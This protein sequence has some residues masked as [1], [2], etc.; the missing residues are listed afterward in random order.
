MRKVLRSIYLDQKMDEA[1]AVRADVE[2]T[3]KAELMRDFIAAGLRRPARN[4]AGRDEAQEVPDRKTRGSARAVVPTQAQAYPPSPPPPARAGH[5]PPPAARGAHRVPPPAL[6]VEPSRA[7][8]DDS[9]RTRSRRVRAS[10]ADEDESDV[11]T[12]RDK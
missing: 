11:V 6:A 12:S 10:S 1:L 9:T 2:R 5:L 8:S 7:D 4:L 3:T